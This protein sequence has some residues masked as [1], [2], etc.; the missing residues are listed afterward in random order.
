MAER[1]RWWVIPGAV[2]VLLRIVTLESGPGPALRAATGSS[3]VTSVG[4]V[5][6]RDAS[7]QRSAAMLLSVPDAFVLRLPGDW[8]GLRVDM[9]AWR[10]I[11]G[12]RDATP[13]F[14]AAPRVRRDAILPIAGMQRGSYDVEITTGEGSARRELRALHLA[15]PGS[16]ELSAK[17]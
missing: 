10:C 14:T 8:A 1:L 7:G 17:H 5:V 4:P 15:M 11:D 13:W 3:P 6:A 2:V 16:H 12:V 9:R